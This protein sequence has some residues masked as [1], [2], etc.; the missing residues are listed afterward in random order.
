MI[1]SY[2]YP[3]FDRMNGLLISLIVRS[4]SCIAEAY[5]AGLSAHRRKTVQ[6]A[7]MSGQIRTVVATVAFGMGLNKPDIRAV[8]HYNMP[9]TFEGYVQEVGR[10]GRDGL[11]A[12]CHLFL[13]PGVM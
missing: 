6:K 9:G 12:H 7:F 1:I 3:L 8:I 10:A 13:N 5:H 2:T 4:I 11:I